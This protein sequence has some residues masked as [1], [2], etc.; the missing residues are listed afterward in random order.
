MIKENGYTYIPKNLRASRTPRYGR[1]VLFMVYDKIPR[2]DW[3][4]E[5]ATDEAEWL[6]IRLDTYTLNVINTYCRPGRPT[7][8]A[9]HGWASI[10]QWLLRLHGENCLLIGDFNCH[11]PAWVLG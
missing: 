1:R 3:K 10:E 7:R 2:T 4:V 9:V 11:H 8:E 5:D 6:R